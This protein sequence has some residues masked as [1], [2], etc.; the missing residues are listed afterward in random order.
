MRPSLPVAIVAIVAL[1]VQSAALARMAPGAASAP[2]DPQQAAAAVMPCHDG[3]GE[4]VPQMPCCADAGCHCDAMCGGAA[5]GLPAADTCAP[6]QVQNTV[7][8]PVTLPMLAAHSS[9]ALRPP[10]ALCN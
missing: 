10:I 2:P 9:E 8:A 1:L 3:A 5:V 7:F 4:P 6:P